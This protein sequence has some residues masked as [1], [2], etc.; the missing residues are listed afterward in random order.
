MKY[1][2]DWQHKDLK[3]Y[4]CGETKSVKYTVIIN[5]PVINNKYTEVFCCNKCALMRATNIK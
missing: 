1:I 2:T 5:D 4:F 3:C